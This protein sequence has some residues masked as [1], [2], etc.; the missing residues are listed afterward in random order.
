VYHEQSNCVV[1]WNT[2]FVRFG[3]LRMLV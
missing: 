3:K 1:Y 2:Y